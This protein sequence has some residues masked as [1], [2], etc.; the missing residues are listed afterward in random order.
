[1][2]GYSRSIM[3]GCIST[4]ILARL[5]STGLSTEPNELLASIHNRDA[6]DPP[7]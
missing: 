5:R 6:G 3:R 2:T 4:S 1:M 7:A